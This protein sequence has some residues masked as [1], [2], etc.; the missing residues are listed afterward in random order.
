MQGGSD[1]ELPLIKR[2]RLDLGQDYHDPRLDDM[3]DESGD[4]EQS[5]ARRLAP[6]M[7]RFLDNPS[8][9]FIK[10]DPPPGIFI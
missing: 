9:E 10:S 2:Q 4:N 7:K 8:T 1:M 3:E 5:Q 6:M